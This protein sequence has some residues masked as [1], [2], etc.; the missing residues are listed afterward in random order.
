[1]KTGKVEIKRFEHD[2]DK[3]NRGI[4]F[5]NGD[6]FGFSLECGNIDNLPFY[7]RI[8]AG[9]YVARKRSLRKHGDCWLLDDKNERTWIILF[10]TGNTRK[11][12]QG[13]IG[14]GAEIGKI[15]GERAIFETKLMCEQFMKETVEFDV[16]KVIIT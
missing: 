7:S 16:M 5:L 12:F 6:F 11:D 10:H 8:N 3:A 1:M 4:V 15:N 14:L 2:S 9:E 13:C